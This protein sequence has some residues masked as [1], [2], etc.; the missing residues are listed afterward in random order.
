MVYRIDEAV[1]VLQRTPGVLRSLLAGLPDVWTTGNEG[2]GTWTPYEV[3]GHLIHGERADWIHRVRHLLE[4]GETRP[5]APFDREAMLRE[6][7]GQTVEQLLDTFDA[8][9]RT[10]LAELAQLSLSDADLFRRP[11]SGAWGGDVEPAS[12]H[13][14][15]TTSRTSRRSCAPWQ[16]SIAKLSDPGTRICL[17]LERTRLPNA[18]RVARAAPVRA[19]G[20][21]YACEDALHRS[22]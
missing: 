9:R 12:R 5:F 13:L 11:S 7:S 18:A 14:G 19:K 3:L 4:Y 16:C 20:A 2:P 8:L 22:C 15:R 10:S 17:C 6:P 21:C 1:A